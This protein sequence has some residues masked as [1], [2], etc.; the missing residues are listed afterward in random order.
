MPEVMNASVIKDYLIDNLVTLTYEC[1]D[2][3]LMEDPSL[4][5]VSCGMDRQWS[6]RPTCIA[7]AGLSMFSVF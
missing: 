3:H 1:D 6:E 7:S 2:A 4:A 5:N